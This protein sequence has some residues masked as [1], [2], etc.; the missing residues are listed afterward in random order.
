MPYRSN[1]KIRTKRHRVP[2]GSDIHLHGHISGG[3]SERSVRIGITVQGQSLPYMFSKGPNLRLP[4][5]AEERGQ[6]SS[7]RT[8]KR[9]ICGYVRL[10]S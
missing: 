1:Y 6:A 9:A 7:K 2:A 4:A 8:A 3:I 5:S 10:S